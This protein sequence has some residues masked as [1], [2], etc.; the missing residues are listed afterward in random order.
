MIGYYRK[1]AVIELD[2]LY[3][4]HDAEVAACILKRGGNIMCKRGEIHFV[5]FGDNIDTYKQSGLRPTLVVSN[6]KVNEHSPVITVVPLTTKTRRMHLPTHVLIP[7]TSG[8]GLNR[9]SLA[10]AEQ[11][12]TLDKDRL[13]EYKG[14]G[15]EQ[16]G[17]GTDNDG[18]AGADR[19]PRGI[20]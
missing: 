12:E 17:H 8:I 18:A 20:Q 11:V 4:A 5:N 16:E 2:K 1:K 14:E 15:Y 7:P 19:C 10:L 9:M 13:L 6:N 3:N